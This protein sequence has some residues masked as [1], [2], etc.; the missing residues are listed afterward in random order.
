MTRSQ[1]AV[2]TYIATSYLS[3]YHFISWVGHHAMQISSA[4]ITVFL[5]DH[6]L[7]AYADKILVPD[8]A[9]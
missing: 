1:V 6:R 3:F 4:T 8:Y 2:N 9:D 5:S 7:L